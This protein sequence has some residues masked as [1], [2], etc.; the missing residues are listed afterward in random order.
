MNNE[1]SLFGAGN[2]AMLAKIILSIVG[3]IGGGFGFAKFVYHIF[4]KY[5]D[6]IEKQFEQN[7]IDHKELF[8]RTDNH[9]EVK[10]C[11]EYCDKKNKKKR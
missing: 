8:G 10:R 1:I 2:I 3:I 9:E 11:I 6:S 4:I 5:F 7:R